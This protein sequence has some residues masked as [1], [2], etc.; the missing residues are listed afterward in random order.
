MVECGRLTCDTP[1]QGRK[2]AVV[3]RVLAALV[4]P[5][6]WVGSD[7]AQ[8]FGSEAWLD[9]IV[10]NWNRPDASVPPAPVVE[11]AAQNLTRCREA[12][13]PSTL[14]ADRA[15]R[16]AG[17]TLF[18]PAQLF[19]ATTVV[20]A[21]ADVDGMCRP[22]RYQAFVFVNGRFA[23]TLSPV[24]MD[25]RTDGALS[26]VRLFHANEMVGEFTRYT[27]TDPLCCPSRTS[28]VIYR[29]D[30]APRAPVVTPVTVSTSPPRS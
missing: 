8:L 7:T 5:V 4:A 25:S 12:R 18:G 13:R 1:G 30:P 21:M 2:E 29:I 3:R 6:L 19:S 22:L 27:A 23:G 17:W 15:V 9:Q 26:I 16:A 24:P 28:T 11:G 20:M 14:A 10:A